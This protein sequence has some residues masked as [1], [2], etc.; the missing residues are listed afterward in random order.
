[1]ASDIRREKGTEETP[2]GAFQYKVEFKYWALSAGLAAGL[3]GYVLYTAS[4]VKVI[5]DI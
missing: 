5:Q 4:Q 3:M 1:M 2:R